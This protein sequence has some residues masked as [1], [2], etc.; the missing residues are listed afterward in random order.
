MRTRNR[1][2]ARLS[3]GMQD[4]IA[5]AQAHGGELVRWEGGF[6]T[7]PGAQSVGVSAGARVPAWWCSWH[8]VRA[9]LDRVLVEVTERRQTKGG[10]EFAVRVRLR[11]TAV[12]PSIN[13][14][15]PGP[16]APRKGEPT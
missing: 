11:A 15:P 5:K 14:A 13:T 3:L 1:G 8:T 2:A 6:W 4:A 16:A 10:G 12:A 9:L 7:H